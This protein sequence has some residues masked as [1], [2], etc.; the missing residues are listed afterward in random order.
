MLHDEIIYLRQGRHVYGNR[1]FQISDFFQHAICE[2]THIKSD[3]KNNYIHP[4]IL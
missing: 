4:V 1:L 2:K 3:I